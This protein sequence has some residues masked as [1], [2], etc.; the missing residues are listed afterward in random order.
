LLLEQVVSLQSSED[1]AE[2]EFVYRVP[3]IAR[4][5]NHPHHALIE[6][7][8]AMP[9]RA[10]PGFKYGR[11]VGAIEATVA[12][13]GIPLTILKRRVW[14]QFHRFRGD[15]KELSCQRALKL[16][17]GAHALFIHKKDHGRAEAALIALTPAALSFSSMRETCRA[18]TRQASEPVFA[19]SEAFHVATFE[20]AIDMLRSV[21]TKPASMFGS[22]KISP[23]DIE[24]ITAFL[25]E[26]A[27]QIAEQRRAA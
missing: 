13:C 17:P 10:S 1:I 12:G 27:K 22:A 19:S 6:R 14:K 18:H 2:R 11:A 15:N 20:K 25:Q 21:E 26:V 9:K 3:N 7:A 16:F 4:A 8:Q 23:N 5:V 24:Q